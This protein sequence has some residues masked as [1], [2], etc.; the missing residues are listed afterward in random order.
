MNLFCIACSWK[1]SNVAFMFKLDSNGEQGVFGSLEGTSWKNRLA[2]IFEISKGELIF[3]VVVVNVVLS[4]LKG[5][6]SA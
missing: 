4:K 5:A 6:R 1:T 2:C 3:V